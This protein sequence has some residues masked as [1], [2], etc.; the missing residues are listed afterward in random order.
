ME[1][2]DPEA[3]LG[4]LVQR[5]LADQLGAE[6]ATT[7]PLIRPSGFADY[8]AN[9]AMSLAR[10]IG[11]P[12]REVAELIATGL[13]SSPELETAEVSGPGF[14]NLTLKDSWIADQATSQLADERAG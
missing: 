6:F 2:T 11:K 13:A 1:M 14:V 8:Q 5:A 10:R 7:D 3:A 4:L 12:P 9:A